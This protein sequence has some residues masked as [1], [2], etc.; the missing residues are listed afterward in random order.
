MKKYSETLTVWQRVP[1]DYND[2]GG[3]ALS[4]Q[5][6]EKYDELISKQI[7]AALSWC[8]D[9]ILAPIDY[10]GDFDISE[11]ISLAATIMMEEYDDE[12]YW[13]EF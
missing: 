2:F 9:E 6:Q 5:G 10:D 3:C 4:E 1:L 13:E 11:A 8:G 7:P 12:K